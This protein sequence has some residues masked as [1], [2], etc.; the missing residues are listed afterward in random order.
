MTRKSMLHVWPIVLIL[1]V[2]TWE[3][4]C[5]WYSGD[6]GLLEFLCTAN[7]HFLFPPPPFPPLHFPLLLTV[8]FVGRLSFRNG[9]CCFSS[10][11]SWIWWLKTRELIELS[12]Q[13][14]DQRAVALGNVAPRD[15]NN[16][17]A[18]KKLFCSRQRQYHDPID[19]LSERKRY[20]TYGHL[21]LI[22]YKHFKALS[23]DIM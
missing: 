23:E 16:S 6:K 2:G 4:I 11:K 15:K 5:V 9:F 18:T 21:T 12:W 13:Q 20:V 10:L 3:K 14:N 1:G 22:S 8:V 7:F 17:L 19:L